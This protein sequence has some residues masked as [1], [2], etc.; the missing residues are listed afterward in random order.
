MRA[1]APLAAALAA[2]ALLVVT[3]PP[4]VAAG[5]GDPKLRIRGQISELENEFTTLFIEYRCATGHTATIGGWIQQRDLVYAALPPRAPGFLC[6]GDRHV[7]Y[8]GFRL[9][10]YNDDDEFEFFD[11]SP[12]APRAIVHLELTDGVTGAVDVDDDRVTLVPR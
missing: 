9:L 5:G 1:R 7:R 11:P 12:G 6:D 8:E 2:I 10:G 4:A 3:A